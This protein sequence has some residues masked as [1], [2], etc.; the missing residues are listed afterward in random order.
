MQNG[1]R[2]ELLNRKHYCNEKKEAKVTFH[3]NAILN[4]KSNLGWPFNYTKQEAFF[5]LYDP[6]W[7]LIFLHYIA[8]LG[9]FEEE[10]WLK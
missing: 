9:M 3:F 2:R 8:K 5:S 4:H 1:L 6:L 7:S 10:Y